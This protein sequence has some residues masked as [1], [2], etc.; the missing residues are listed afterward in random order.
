MTNRNDCRANHP[1]ASAA[2]TADLSMG[3][4][5]SDRHSLDFLLVSPIRSESHGSSLPDSRPGTDQL[6]DEDEHLMQTPSAQAGIPASANG[7]VESIPPAP[8]QTTASESPASMPP[9]MNH[10][11]SVL[12][13]QRQA[14]HELRRDATEERRHR[15]EEHAERSSSSER[16][17]SPAP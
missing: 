11:L 6:A 2:N 12:D 16:G 14:L 10:F 5:P 4:T 15:A 8:P 9:W 17:A 3:P 7:L 13:L 1:F